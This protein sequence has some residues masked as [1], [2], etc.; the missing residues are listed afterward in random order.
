MN[1]F[2]K[3]ETCGYYTPVGILHEIKTFL[4]KAE[5]FPLGQLYLCGIKELF[6]ILTKYFICDVYIGVLAMSFCVTEGNDNCSSLGQ[7]FKWLKAI[8]VHTQVFFPQVKHL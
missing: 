3:V 1:P 5:H 4:Y 7:I 6:L 8:I 2:F